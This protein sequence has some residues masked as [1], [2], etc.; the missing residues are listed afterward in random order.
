MG[1]LTRGGGKK[2]SNNA[3]GAY[4]EQGDF[5]S[6]KKKKQKLMEKLES[7][8]LVSKD[9]LGIGK[10]HPG[11]SEESWSAFS[12]SIPTPSCTLGYFSTG[13]GYQKIQTF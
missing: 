12:L 11:S 1:A 6:G 10:F 4:S 8:F 9:L 3:D 13:F 2:D 7:A 5:S